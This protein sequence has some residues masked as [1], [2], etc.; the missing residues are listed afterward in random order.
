[1]S[2]I[3]RERDSIIRASVEKLVSLGREA[4]QATVEGKH[5]TQKY[6]EGMAL[7]TIFEAYTKYSQLDDKEV[8]TLLYCLRRMSGAYAFPTVQPLLGQPINYIIQQI[9]TNTGGINLDPEP[10]S[11]IWSDGVNWQVISVNQLAQ[12]LAPHILKY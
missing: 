1:M 3:I 10:D 5:A 4:A 12:K 7:L 2:E 8:E 9:S 11:V 6:K